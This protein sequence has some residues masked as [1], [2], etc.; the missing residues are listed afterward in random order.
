[1]NKSGYFLDELNHR[2]MR[3]KPLIKE[4]LNPGIKVHEKPSTR[5][6][7]YRCYEIHFDLISNKQTKKKP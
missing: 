5:R 3:N 2:H 1:M 4:S 6:K 7:I